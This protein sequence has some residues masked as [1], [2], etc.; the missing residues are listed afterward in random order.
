MQTTY[1]LIS[2][3][4]SYRRAPATF[5]IHPQSERESL[6]PG[7][8]VKLMFRI[9]DY[10]EE[11]VERMWVIVEEVRPEYYVGVLDNDSLFSDEIIC[12]LEVQFHSDHVTDID[13]ARANRAAR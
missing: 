11:W 4:E 2:A 13:R 12:G 7:D 1:T 3:V 5:E 6:R 10:G 9:S 8:L